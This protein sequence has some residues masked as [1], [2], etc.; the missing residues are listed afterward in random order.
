MSQE[1]ANVAALLHF[2][3]GTARSG[4]KDF[5]RLRRLPGPPTQAV[6]KLLGIAEAKI[7]LLI[8]SDGIRH[9]LAQH[10]VAKPKLK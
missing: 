3:A 7:N 2:M 10:G 8:D 1:V 6:A 4:A 9:T 5:C